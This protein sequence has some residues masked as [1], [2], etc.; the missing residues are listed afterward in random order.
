MGNGRESNHLRKGDA[1]Q[2]RRSDH[3]E[4]CQQNDSHLET[5]ERWVRFRQCM[6]ARSTLSGMK[7]GFRSLI[8]AVGAVSSI[9][10]VEF[11]SAQSAQSPDA[12]HSEVV[13]TKLAQPRYPPLAR[14]ARIQGDVEVTVGVRKDGSIE[15][16]VIASGHALLKEAA[17]E[18]AQNSQYEC[19]GRREAV[20]SCSLLYTFQPATGDANQP[21][22]AAVTQ[23]RN[24]IT[25]V[26]E[27]TAAIFDVWPVRVRSAEC[28]YLWK[29][30]LRY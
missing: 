18:S 20:T 1:R 15:S 10:F 24:H 8:L 21:Q 22:V 23:S 3:Q 30:G 29:C 7:H 9:T 17:L 16:A 27:P 13:L 28:L 19:R 25:V 4:E 2:V 11:A 12:P 6:L 5:L 14:Q 26:A